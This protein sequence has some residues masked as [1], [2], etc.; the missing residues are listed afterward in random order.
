MRRARR[1]FA[2]LG[3][4]FFLACGKSHA[5]P[6]S[7]F[8]A[9]DRE[10]VFDATEPS[11]GDA[12]E[13]AAAEA[14]VF[15]ALPLFSDTLTAGIAE[16]VGLSPEEAA[17]LAELER[18]RDDTEEAARISMHLDIWRETRGLSAEEERIA[19]TAEREAAAKNERLLAEAIRR[20]ATYPEPLRA[21]L[22][23]FYRTED[24]LRGDTGDFCDPSRGLYA[25]YRAALREAGLAPGDRRYAAARGAVL[26]YL[27]E[28]L[29]A[30]R[31]FRTILPP[32]EAARNL[33]AWKAAREALLRRLSEA[34][35]ANPAA[36]PL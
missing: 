18:A 31:S 22:L 8:T 16:L 7:R 19:E 33:A 5:P 27:D 6:A 21:R 9:C 23:L 28:A 10:A 11:A 20:F 35:L 12:S 2:L 30:R 26:S 34:G 32:D 15:S 3:T 17:A 25:P 1:F 14:F 24:A 36:F 29:P 13:T 4:V